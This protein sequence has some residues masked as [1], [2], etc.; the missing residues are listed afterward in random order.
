[1]EYYSVEN[2]I[3]LFTTWM[4]IESI[5]PNKMSVRKS[6]IHMISQMSKGKRKREGANQE[7]GS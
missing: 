6:Q 5:M 7:A 2:E 3:L 1:M 4:E